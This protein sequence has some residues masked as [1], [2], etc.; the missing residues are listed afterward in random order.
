MNARIEYLYDR[1]HC[2]GHSYFMNVTLFEKL[3]SVFENK[4]I[5]L[6]AEYFYEDWENIDLVLNQ[7]GM[8]EEKSNNKYI[9]SID[10]T[11]GNKI[12]KINYDNFE[13]ENFQKIYDDNVLS[14]E[15]E[16]SNN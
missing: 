16:Q 12:Y 15:N 3:K 8:I 2:I 11:N 14:A 7:N 1:E 6:L 10:K 5:P 9:K 13:I 4:I